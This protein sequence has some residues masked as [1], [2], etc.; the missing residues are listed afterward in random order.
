MSYK[1][2]KIK[3]EE[4]EIEL[5]Q[6]L[7]N[8]TAP[9]QKR[10]EESCRKFFNFAVLKRFKTHNWIRVLAGIQYLRRNNIDD[11]LINK[12]I[13][14]GRLSELQILYDKS[15]NLFK[16]GN[17]KLML[18]CSS[19]HWLMLEWICAVFNI[20]PT[21]EDFEKTTVYG[22]KRRDLAQISIAKVYIIPIISIENKDH[23]L[24]NK[25][26]PIE[27]ENSKSTIH[28]LNMNPDLRRRLY[29]NGCV[30]F[31]IETKLLI[32]DFYCINLYEFLSSIIIREHNYLRNIAK[33][34]VELFAEYINSEEIYYDE[35]NS[36]HFF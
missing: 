13:E 9:D 35:K 27:V 15:P 20:H 2:A 25:G 12:L 36:I 17:I 18:A 32:E 29:M 31:I 24:L 4:I 3:E 11:R 5:L 28:L 14:S 23:L 21:E 30:Y 6:L 1:I 33:H 16:V 7:A 19:E 10:A 22:R 26:D 8:I 34:L